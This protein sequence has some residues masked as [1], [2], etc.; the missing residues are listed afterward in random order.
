ALVN[1]S[2]SAS[3]PDIFALVTSI[4]QQFN[5]PE[6]ITDW[7]SGVFFSLFLFFPN[8]LKTLLKDSQ[9]TSFPPSWTMDLEG[10]S[11]YSRLFPMKIWAPNIV[12]S[13]S[14]D[15]KNLG[16]VSPTKLLSGKRSWPLTGPP[17]SPPPHEVLKPFDPQN[18]DLNRQSNIVPG[19]SNSKKPV[20]ILKPDHFSSQVWAEFH[21]GRQGTIAGGR[22]GASD[23]E[24]SIRLSHTATYGIWEPVIQENDLCAKRGTYE[25]PQ[26]MSLLSTPPLQQENS[27]AEAANTDLHQNHQPNCADKPDTLFNNVQSKNLRCPLRDSTDRLPLPPTDFQ[28]QHSSY[29]E[30]KCLKSRSLNRSE[31]SCVCYK[32]PIKQ[33]YTQTRESYGRCFAVQPFGSQTAPRRC[34][35]GKSPSGKGN[36]KLPRSVGCSGVDWQAPQEVGQAWTPLCALRKKKKMANFCDLI[37]PSFRAL[38]L[39]NSCNRVPKYGAFHPRPF[40]P[41]HPSFSVRV[42]YSDILHLTRVID[43]LCG[44]TS[45]LYRPSSPWHRHHRWVTSHSRAAHTLY[46][47]LDE[48]FKQ[49]RMLEKERRKIEADLKRALPGKF[50]TSSSSI[51]FYRLPANPSQVCILLEK[52]EHFWSDSIHNIILASLWYHLEAI[53]TTQARRKVEILNAGHPRRP[54]TSSEVL[55]LASA[56]NKLTSSTRK[57]RTALWCVFQQIVFPKILTRVPGE[58]ALDLASVPLQTRSSQRPKTKKTRE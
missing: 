23:T 9:P 49:W 55:A 43:V 44:G 34:R 8:I 21:E 5:E 53:C 26:F 45:A 11:G 47:H 40:S 7:Y 35:Y 32:K 25:S 13:Q 15:K 30:D 27:I 37:N 19:C 20:Y 31:A 24:K 28:R 6:A 4:L 42:Q 56:L 58:N 22:L 16:E 14:S 54:G 50:F 46:V 2:Y 17:G 3:G 18:K 51:A 48:C 57:T 1:L 36:L 39:A 33:M 12:E 29:S 38:L 52:M 41:P 10:C